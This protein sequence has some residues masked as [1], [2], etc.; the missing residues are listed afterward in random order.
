MKSDTRNNAKLKWG[1][2]VLEN[3]HCGVNGHFR[4][5]GSANL[6]NRGLL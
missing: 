4:V 1:T 3:A 2:F 5:I 6:V